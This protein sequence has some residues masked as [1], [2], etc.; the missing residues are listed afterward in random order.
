MTLQD[1]FEVAMDTSRAATL[2]EEQRAGFY[3]LMMQSTVSDATGD[4]P[5]DPDEASRFDAWL[6]LSGTTTE[7]AMQRFVDLAQ[8][9]AP[10]PTSARKCASVSRR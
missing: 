1:D 10:I 6:A 7:E 8:T 9:L 3:S 2:D 5:S 4:Q